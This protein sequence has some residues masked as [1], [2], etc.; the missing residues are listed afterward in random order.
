MKVNFM[1][2]N[3]LHAFAMTS[4]VGMSIPS[5]E[6]FFG[7]IARG[8]STLAGNFFIKIII[9]ACQFC[10]DHFLGDVNYAGGSSLDAIFK[11]NSTSEGES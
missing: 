5:R 8:K 10:Q 11:G 4:S 6:S 2:L 1:Q 7:N 9:P 3:K